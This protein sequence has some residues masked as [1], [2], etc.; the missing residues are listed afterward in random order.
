[1]LISKLTNNEKLT[2]KVFIR[3]EEDFVLFFK[4][5]FAKPYTLIN[6]PAV[7]KVV[8][9][10]WDQSLFPSLTISAILKNLRLWIF[11]ISSPLNPSMNKLHKICTEFSDEISKLVTHKSNQYVYVGVNDSDTLCLTPLMVALVAGNIKGVE[12]LIKNGA[13]INRCP[14]T[15]NIKVVN[16]CI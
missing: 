13:D 10:L 3:D 12:K 14:L 6:L 9:L 8:K 7:R 5:F 11:G 4:F 2:E 15:V 16:E 1:L